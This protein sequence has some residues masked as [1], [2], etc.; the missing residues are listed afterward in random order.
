MGAF[1]IF[2]IVLTFLYAGYYAVMIAI[3]L[4]GKKG[5]K[6]DVIEEFQTENESEDAEED[7]LTDV[8][9]TT[10][11]WE[12]HSASDYVA[13]DEKHDVEGGD[14][15]HT[16]SEEEREISITKTDS[17]HQAVIHDAQRPLD[18]I[19]PEYQSQK[20]STEMLAEMRQPIEQKT[21]SKRVLVNV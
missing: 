7:M 17:V 16:P 11:G 13:T 1:G 19:C 18:S 15:P 8:I 4:Y 10:G 5:K 12:V 20:L 9:E 3:D 21:L 2:V 14:A 6:E